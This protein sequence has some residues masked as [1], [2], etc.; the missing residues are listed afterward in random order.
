MKKGKTL[1]EARED[2]RDNLDTARHK[3]RKTEYL[4]YPYGCLN[5]GPV[6]QGG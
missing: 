4:S 6:S 5:L 1:E 3:K 2:Q